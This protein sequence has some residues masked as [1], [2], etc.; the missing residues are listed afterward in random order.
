M[1]VKNY[2]NKQMYYDSVFLMKL[3]ER[4]RGMEEVGQVSAGMG[5]PLNKSTLEDMGLLQEEGRRG[6]SQ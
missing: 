3:A 4:L 2:V 6:G 5:T 1:V